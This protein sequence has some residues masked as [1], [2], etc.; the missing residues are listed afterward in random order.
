[1]EWLKTR[2]EEIDVNSLGG[3]GEGEAVAD[4]FYTTSTCT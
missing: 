4:R 1:M 3:R 2:E